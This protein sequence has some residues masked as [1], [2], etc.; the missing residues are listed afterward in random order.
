MSF[1]IQ[2]PLLRRVADRAAFIEHLIREYPMFLNQWTKQTEEKFKKE[3]E[4]IAK[5]DPEVAHSY[6]SNQLSAFDDNEYRLDIFYKAMVM[7]A[8]SYY[9]SVI[10]SLLKQ[11]NVDVK[12]KVELICRL[13]N[14]KLSEEA[15]NAKLYLKTNFRHLRNELVHNND[16]EANHKRRINIIAKNNKDVNMSEDCISLTGPDFILDCLQKETVVLKEL[17]EKL[18]FQH[19]KVD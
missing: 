6:Y 3:M 7:I 13:N 4:E 19:K 1:T 10:N 5:D 8:Y 17:C 9:E 14:I 16:N 15:E 12:D 2:D 18:G 11:Q